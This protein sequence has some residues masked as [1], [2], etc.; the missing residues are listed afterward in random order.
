MVTKLAI[1]NCVLAI[2]SATSKALGGNFTIT[3][4]KKIYFTDV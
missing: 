1:Y 3:H 4:L 2:Q